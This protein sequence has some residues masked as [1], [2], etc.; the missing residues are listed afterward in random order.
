[1]GD[2]LLEA[3]HDCGKNR[4]VS[5]MNLWPIC[6]YRHSEVVLRHVISY[7]NPQGEFLSKKFNWKNS[8]ENQLEW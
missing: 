5:T 7:Q 6:E 1:M 3:S 4:S 2:D 8:I